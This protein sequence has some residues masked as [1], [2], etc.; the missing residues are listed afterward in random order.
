MKPLLQSQTHNQ[1]FSNFMSR[2]TPIKTI[3]VLMTLMVSLLSA[4]YLNADTRYRV[5]SSDT[6]KRIIA[7][8]YPNSSLSREQLMIEIFSRNRKAFIKNNI[9]RLKRGYRLVLPSEENI[10]AVSHREAKAILKRGTKHYRKS[11]SSNAG[12]KGAEFSGGEFNNS[13]V[14]NNDTSPR[15]SSAASELLSEFELSGNDL[16]ILGAV[17]LEKDVESFVVESEVSSEAVDAEPLVVNRTS[18]QATK[19]AINNERKRRNSRRA[20]K[21]MNKK[22][23]ATSRRKLTVA[24]KQ[25]RKIAEERQ[26]LKDQL[27]QLQ[28]EKRISDSRLHDLDV[29][30]QESVKLSSQLKSDLEAKTESQSQ[31]KDAA[32]EATTFLKPEEINAQKASIQEDIIAEGKKKGIL[33]RQVEEKTQ[34][35]KESN[36]VFQQKLQEARSELAENTRENIALERQLNALKNQKNKPVTSNSP[37]PALPDQGANNL[38][39]REAANSVAGDIGAATQSNKSLN[40]NSGS[41]KFLWLLP[42]LA[43]F[44]ALWFVLR[45][46]LGAN[47]GVAIT[48]EGDTFATTAFGSDDGF[49]ESYEEVSLETSIKLDVARAYIEADDSQS[50][51]EMLEEVIAEGNDEQQLE[52]REIMA[53]IF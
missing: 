53:K 46:F 17:Q 8:K 51:R 24:K 41:N 34:K 49:D 11:E 7:K 35:L 15:I 6:V 1:A 26:S 31:N 47:Q 23:L 3:I 44:G 36:T 10:Q 42:V 25:L 40:T 21:S 33:E 14:S 9:N 30:F 13:E 48:N 5:K 37:A 29:K 27:E 4:S 20:E 19:R 32:S 52:A 16:E 12:S 38:P 45:R 43:L 22:E 28:Q 50:A 39:E 18:R 2:F